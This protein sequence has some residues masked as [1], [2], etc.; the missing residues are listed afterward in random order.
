MS[1][2]PMPVVVAGSDSMAAGYARPANAASTLADDVNAAAEALDSLRRQLFR[3]FP[4][5][6]EEAPRRAP[7]FDAGELA[8]DRLPWQLLPMMSAH[9][10]PQLELAPPLPDAVMPSVAPEPRRF[11]I[12]GFLAGVALSAAIGAL[13]YVVLAAR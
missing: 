11:E 12:R 2:T 8:P 13:L 7:K 1:V 9:T 10:L 4:H 5:P 3:Q 6:V